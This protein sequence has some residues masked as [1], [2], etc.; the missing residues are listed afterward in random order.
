MPRD[1]RGCM[2]DPECGVADVVDAIEVEGERA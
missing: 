2:V 1:L